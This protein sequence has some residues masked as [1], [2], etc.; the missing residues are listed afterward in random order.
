MADIGAHL[1]REEQMKLYRARR[2]VLEML[3]DRGYIV[4]EDDVKID[5]EEF[6]KRYV[7]VDQINEI[8]E[9]VDPS[10][11][12][13][14]TKFD[15]PREGKF[16]GPGVRDLINE[17]SR[18]NIS[19]MIFIIKEGTMT[20][21]AKKS[22][23]ALKTQNPPLHVELFDEKEVLINITHHELV[24]KHR[25]LSADEKKAFLEKT[26]LKDAQLPRIQKSDPVVRYLG[27]DVGTVLEITRKS[28]T[29][30][31]YV[32]YRLVC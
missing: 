17:A 26:N 7:T 2:T 12:R 32:T 21:M 22:I 30:D 18:E 5:F 25:P 20:P 4:D 3:T 16:G 9:H 23:A 13:I 1:G 15:G 11:P 14:K 6:R 29:A 19:R 27:V 10:M 24:P 8:Y 31:R 28:E